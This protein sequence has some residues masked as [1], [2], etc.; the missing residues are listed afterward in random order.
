MTM[1]TRKKELSG[2]VSSEVDYEA[3]KELS[4]DIASESE[5]ESTVTISDINSINTSPEINTA[6]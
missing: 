4:D 6:W 3:E 2:N 5:N 1:T